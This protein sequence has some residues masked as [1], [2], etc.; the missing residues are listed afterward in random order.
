[1]ETFSMIQLQDALF[2]CMKSTLQRDVYKLIDIYVQHTHTENICDLDP[3]YFEMKRGMYT[4]TQDMYKDMIHI[5]YDLGYGDH[6]TELMPYI[7]YYLA[8]Y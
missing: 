4:S 7:D 3:S 5:I 6:H 1:M 2:V 8:F